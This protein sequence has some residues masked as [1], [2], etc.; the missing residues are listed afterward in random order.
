MASWVRFSYSALGP[1]SQPEFDGL[2]G[3]LPCQGQ[4]WRLRAILV[5]CHSPADRYFPG[6]EVSGLQ[7]PFFC[8]RQQT[9][10]SCTLKLDFG[11]LTQIIEN[12]MRPGEVACAV[13][14]RADLIGH[15]FQSKKVG[16]F[17]FAMWVNASVMWRNFVRSPESSDGMGSMRL[18]S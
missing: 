2:L 4:Q 10:R 12:A 17:G 11:D 1:I 6:H 15:R 13:P 9:I 7:D 18:A 8:I 14:I 5:S 3:Q 16:E